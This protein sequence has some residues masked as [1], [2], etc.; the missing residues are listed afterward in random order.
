MTNS[1]V[2]RMLRAV[3]LMTPA[4]MAMFTATIGGLVAT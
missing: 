2:S 4:R 3:S 1:P